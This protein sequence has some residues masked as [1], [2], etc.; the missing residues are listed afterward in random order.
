MYMCV[1]IYISIY[2]PHR[3]LPISVVLPP[4]RPLSGLLFFFFITL[5]LELSDTTSQRALNK[6]P[7]R[8]CFSLLRSNCSCIENCTVRYR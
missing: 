7:P 2:K 6:S 4:P 3:A 1:C 5:G 8:N